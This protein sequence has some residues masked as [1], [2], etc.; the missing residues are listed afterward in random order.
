MD[1]SE[2]D[3][4]ALATPV[5]KLKACLSAKFKTMERTLDFIENK[6]TTSTTSLAFVSYSRTA[7]DNK[8]DEED[9]CLSLGPSSQEASFLSDNCPS[10]VPS[11]ADCETH[12]DQVP[13]ENLSLKAKVYAIW[14]ELSG[15]DCRSSPLRN[16]SQ[17]FDF[18]FCSGLV[19]NSSKLYLTFHEY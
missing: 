14:R 5:Q 6:K 1:S 16:S 12:Q 10:R 11:V 4:K 19:R 13:V 15:L 9:D 18:Q 7:L 17:P 8:A 3:I 2:E